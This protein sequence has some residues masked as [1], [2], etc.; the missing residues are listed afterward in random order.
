M[1]AVAAVCIMVF[2]MV[3]NQHNPILFGGFAKQLLTANVTNVNLTD[4]N[5]KVKVCTVKLLT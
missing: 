3:F 4:R 5:E 1:C 2:N